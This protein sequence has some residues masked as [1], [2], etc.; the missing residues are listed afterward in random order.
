MEQ[1]T[2]NQRER[3]AHIDFTLL[4]K[5]EITRADLTGRFDIAA[6][7]A[8]KDLALYRSLA[9]GNICYD[10]RSKLHT[11]PEGFTPLF[12]YDVI[13]TLT[14]LSQG[15]G[16]GLTSSFP[17]AIPCEVPFRLNQP[18]LLTV[19]C[20]SEAIY[21]G[22][23]VELEY[24]SLSSGQSQRQLVPH[25]LVDTGLRWHVRGYDRKS[26]SF[27]D[28]VLTRITSV[29]LCQ[30]QAPTAEERALA[31]RQWQRYV[32]LELIPHPRQA[33]GDAIAL[34]YAMHNDVLRLEVRAALAG[35]LLRLWNV[36]CSPDHRLHGAE[37]QLA[38]ANHATLYGVD[39]LGLA[40]GYVL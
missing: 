11:R 9:P 34:D 8:T 32:E 39:N 37:Y 26:A 27:R 6:V 23:A 10:R 22:R 20:L 35:Y 15:F 21:K 13:R 4:F 29:R 30:E 14:S 36:D 38:L 17:S 28:F 16:D 33:H 2:R 7:Q 40:P 24:C 1:L 25:S 31:D 3:L 12:D 5:G 19:A 18:D